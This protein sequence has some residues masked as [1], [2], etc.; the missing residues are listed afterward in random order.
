MKEDKYDSACKIFK[1]TGI[2][3][4]KDGHKHLGAVIGTEEFKTTFVSSKVSGWVCDVQELAEIA[5]EEPQI[6]YCAFTK[7]L[8]RRWTYTQRT[9]S[10]IA[11]LFQ[12][13]EVAIRDT[14]IPA[15]VG[16]EVSDVE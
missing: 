12:R 10:N 16:R 2:N 5:K 9:I 4:T 6:A 3:I 13:L 8:C 7:G 1:N 11:Q 14:L 15:I